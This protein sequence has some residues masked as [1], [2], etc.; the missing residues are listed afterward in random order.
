MT[1]SHPPRAAARWLG[2]LLLLA[3]VGGA[4][5]ALAS[6]KRDSLDAVDAA[7]RSQPEPVSVIEVA[8]VAPLEHVDTATAI[9][10][11]RALRSITLQNEVA[12]TVRE[13]FLESGAIVEEGAV[14]IA[15]DTSVEEAELHA[16]EAQA[17]L[18]STLHGRVERA[19]HSRGASEADVDRAGAELA[20]AEANVERVRALIERKRIRAPFRAHVGL[21][22]IHR[23]QYLEVGSRLTTL[24]GVDS[25]AHVEFN[26]SQDVAAGLRVGQKLQIESVRADAQYEAELA[27]IDARVDPLTRNATLRALIQGA[28]GTLSPGASVRVRVPI[29]EPRRLA[30]IPVSALRKGPGGDHVFVLAEHDGVLR[31]SQRRVVSGPMLGDVIAVL[32]GLEV[33]DRVAASGSFKLFDG[34]R[35]AIAASSPSSADGASQQD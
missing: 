18:A 5:V 33:G 14:L 32:E 4:A 31:A 27:A 29:G 23:G 12:G 15:L 11:V 20:V 22:D 3:S 24:Q 30:V 13:V 34:M 21:A 9:G 2:S 6:W 26:V 25:A 19:M 17:R 35:V 1:A 28:E 7:A 8:D 16:L 10:T